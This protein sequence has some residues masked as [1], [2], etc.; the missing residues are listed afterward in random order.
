MKYQVKDKEGAKAYNDSYFL[1]CHWVID[2]G[3]LTSE[4]LPFSEPNYQHNM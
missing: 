2:D 1:R 4:N 3:K